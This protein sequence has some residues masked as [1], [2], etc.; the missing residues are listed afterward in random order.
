MNFCE[1]QFFRTWQH[2][3]L[4][5][6]LL[7]WN[8]KWMTKLNMGMFK[9]RVTIGLFHAN[10]TIKAPTQREASDSDNN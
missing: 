6:F 5:G 8:V 9:K 1:T 7:T 2:E 4:G 10:N 3:T